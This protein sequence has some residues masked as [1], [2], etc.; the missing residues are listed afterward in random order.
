MFDLY[1]VEAST[2]LADWTR[3]ALLLRTNNNPTPLLFQDTHVAGFSQRFYRAH[4]NHLITGF[5]KP[6]GPFAV[7]TF[8]RILTDSSR[9]NRYGIKTNN[10]SMS[11]FWYPA[12][13]L[14][15]GSLPGAY[16]ERI[17]A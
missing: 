2:N 7:G 17:A 9:S 3:L 6:T 4:T 13:P 15:A 8:S 12:E 14:R 11:T 16:N 10:S 5:P 1:L